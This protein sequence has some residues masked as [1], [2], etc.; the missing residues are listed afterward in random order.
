MATDKNTPAAPSLSEWA[1]VERPKLGRFRAEPNPFL[2]LLP[3]VPTD[4]Q[5]YSA[6]YSKTYPALDV[7]KSVA[8]KL[9]RAA[10]ELGF[11]MS[12]LINDTDPKAVILTW[13]V[14]PKRTVNKDGA[15]KTPT[16][17][18]TEAGAD[19]A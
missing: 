4:V 17:G 2:D 8:A 9:R 16:E 13:A 11:G 18:A 10:K 14:I 12:V 19:A 1:Q 7:A 15:V 3:Q 5:G 6:G